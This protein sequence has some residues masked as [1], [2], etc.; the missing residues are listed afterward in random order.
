MVPGDSPLIEEAVVARVSYHVLREERAFH[1]ARSLSVSVDPNGDHIAKPIDLIKLTPQSG[2]KSPFIVTIYQYPGLN[3]ILNLLDLG[4]AV[5]WARK[6]GD[7]WQSYRKDEFNLPPPITLHS[8][9]DFAIGATQCLEMIHHSQGVVHGEIRADA[10][11]YNIETNKVKLLTF[12]S[13]LRSFEHGLTSAGWSTLSKELGV[14]N[15][16]QYISPEQTGRMPAEPD[17][18]TDIYSLGIL[19]WSLLT[20]KPVFE[21]ENPLDLVQN[22]LRRRTSNVSTIRMDVPEVIGKIIQKCTAK[23]VGDRYHSASGLRY[24]LVKVQEFLRDGDSL[25]LKEWQIGSRD[26]SS[27]FVLPT[28]MV[29]R[30]RERDKFVK[31]IDR[32]AKSHALSEKGGANRFSD[33]SSLSNELLEWADGSSEGASSGGDVSNRRSGS[34]TQ[35]ISSDQKIRHGGQ[36]SGQSVDAQTISG[37]TMSS[38]HS[39]PPALRLPQRAWERHQSV[40]F[41]TRSLVDT[42]GSD[43]EGIRQSVAATDASSSLSRQLGSAKF[44]RRGGCEIVVIEGIGGSGKSCLIQS[45]LPEARRRGYCATAKFDNTRRAA[46]GPLLSL[47]SSLFRQ[48]WNEPNTDTAFHQSLKQYVRP[49]WGMLHKLLSLPDFLLGPAETTVTRSITSAQGSPRAKNNRV[50]EEAQR[51]SSPASPGRRSKIPSSRISTQSSQDFLR[52]G[53]STKNTMRFMNIFLDV[54]RMFTNHKFICLCLEDLHYAG[55]ESLEF[56]TQLISAGMKMVIIITYRPEEISPD[57]IN[58]VIHPPES[59]GKF[60]WS[61]RLSRRP[62]TEV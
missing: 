17:T 25:A 51:G 12:G 6:V 46:Y 52:S 14:K 34:F 19:F 15:K 10:F 43:R 16:L 18:R 56:I 57:R 31:V 38:G 60:C 36:P 62:L 30:D 13:G 45:V 47:L 42:V 26:V 1:I 35:A 44:R 24:D 39:N 9:M 21:G 48:V 2:D 8:F 4:P 33:G 58:A 41:E 28:I 54:L 53:T 61:R 29:G 27:F 37:E 23:N 11:H 20:Q 50:G 59:E 32:L 55:A 49:N 22:I 5:F 40:S 3:H 7:I